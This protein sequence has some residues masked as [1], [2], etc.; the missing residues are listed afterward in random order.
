MKLTDIIV[1]MRIKIFTEVHRNIFV[2]IELC[3]CDRNKEMK[4]S[5]VMLNIDLD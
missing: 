3:Q 4:P 5:R 2:V 1:T